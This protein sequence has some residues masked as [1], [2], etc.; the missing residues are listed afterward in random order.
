MKKTSLAGALIGIAML[1]TAHAA[2]AQESITIAYFTEWAMPFEYAK[3][4]GTFDKE[5]GVKVNWRAFDTGT[6]MSAAMA[7]GDVQMAVSQGVPPFLVA[8]SAGQDLQ[9]VDVAVSYSGNDNC[10]VSDRLEITGKN[11]KE[12]EGKTAAIPIGTAAQYDFLKQMEHFGVDASKIH[13][14]DMAPPEGAAALA[15][16]NVD[17]ACGFGGGLV[18]MEE[19][20]HVLMTGDEKDAIGLH[21]YDLISAR[22]EFVG[23]SP[24]LVAK[25][26]KVVH[27]AND[28]W[29]SGDAAKAEM[30]P[31]IA[32]DAGMDEPAAKKM[33]AGFK[34]LSV[35][36]TLGQMWLGGGVQKNLKDVADFFQTTGNIKQALPSYDDLVNAGPLKAASSM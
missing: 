36:D 16:G 13:V 32:Q 7:S 33:L 31:V 3:V 20:G 30:L 27:Q 12:L 5:M 2:A 18:R 10:V 17:M 25:F 34:F 28:K 6:A 24:D 26:L 8:T 19:H 1:G 23:N 4:N 11:A 9:A 29:N 14:V 21:V 22:S 15:Q 35:P